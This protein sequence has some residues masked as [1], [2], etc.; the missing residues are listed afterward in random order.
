[1]AAAEG[2]SLVA[3]VVSAAAAAVGAFVAVSQ[4]RAT[5]PVRPTRT[6][7]TTQAHPGTETSPPERARVPARP[8]DRA[9][10]ITKGPRRRDKLRRYSITAV[11]LGTVACG[12]FAL[13]FLLDQLAEASDSVLVPVFLVS[14]AA[15]I[16]GF[17][18]GFGVMV[19]SLT[20]SRLVDARTAS[21]GLALA[22]WPWVALFV[23]GR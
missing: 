9:T 22:L 8:T 20:R 21:V 15:T 6:P 18:V 23:F 5:R 16:L 17:V 4:W 14:I 10:R 19:A 7:T 3:T 1:M 11:V 13:T 2:V 12:T